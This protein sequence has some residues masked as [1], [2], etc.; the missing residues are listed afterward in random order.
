MTGQV[1]RPVGADGRGPSAVARGR[2]RAVVGA[3]L[4]G[5][6]ALA[7][8]LAACSPVGP[9]GAAQGPTTPAVTPAPDPTPVATPP[10]AADVRATGTPV[11]SGTVTVWVASPAPAGSQDAAGTVTATAEADGSVRV[12]V[13]AADPAGVTLLAVDTGSLFEEQPD[14]S[15][16]IR[17]AAGTAVGALGRPTSGRRPLQ[18]VA[19]GDLLKVTASAVST[20]T[21]PPVSASFD[22]A[23]RALESATWG[24]R[25]GG[26]S[27]AVVPSPW[28]RSGND[29]AV[30]LVWQQVLATAPDADVPGMRDQLVCHSVGAPDKES[31]NLEPWRPDVGLLATLAAACNA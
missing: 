2:R 22:L 1:T 26:R 10:T 27:L 14:G 15:V 23:T 7:L 29:A 19:E 9:A 6:C 31:W 18:H 24:E 8:A 5:A 16:L 13:T 4:A 12:D 28:G 30:A 21:A 3:A 17:D 25:E 11:T 20:S